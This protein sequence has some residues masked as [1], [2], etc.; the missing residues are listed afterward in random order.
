MH[1]QFVWYDL[2]T[3]DPGA[4]KKFYPALFGWKTQRFEHSAPDNPY[5]MW[6]SGGE[7]LGGVMQLSADERSQGI[8]PHWMSSVQ[9]RN[10]DESARQAQSLGARVVFGPTDIPATGRYAALLDPQGAL[11]AIFQPQGAMD[12]FDGTPSRG[13][14]SWNELMTTDFRKAFD[15]YRQLF[16]W[17]KTGEFDMGGGSMYL[18]FGAKGKSYGGMFNKLPGMEQVPSFWLPYVNVSDVNTAVAAATKAGAT[19]A[20]GPMEVPG[21]DWI[22]AFQDP[23]GAHFAV[24][25]V[26]L[27]S[28]SRPAAKATPKPKAKTKSK[29]SARS[30]TKSKSKA[31]AS[32]KAKARSTSRP[33]AKA[34]AKAKKKARRR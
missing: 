2:M 1:G 9:V 3:S 30:R 19:L 20:N 14:V 32:P 5:T 25:Q 17:E 6:A 4:A 10:V 26:A 11:I 21:G 15:F 23:Q 16:R 8:P 28:G 33:R 31:K 7:T 18:T 34:K 13:R 24:H 27:K 29:S 12:G 22:A